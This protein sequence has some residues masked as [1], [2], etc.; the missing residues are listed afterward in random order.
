[1]RSG[2]Q[3]IVLSSGSHGSVTNGSTIAENAGHGIDVLMSQADVTG[4]DTIRDNSGSSIGGGTARRSRS[5]KIRS[6]E[7]RGTV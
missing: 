7:T 6:P 1:M 2:A 4:N 5:T 3:G